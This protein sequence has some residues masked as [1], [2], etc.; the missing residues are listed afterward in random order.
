MEKETAGTLAVIGMILYI[1]FVGC[2]AFGLLYG[3]VLLAQKI[4]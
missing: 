2:L 1:L 3:A 4:F